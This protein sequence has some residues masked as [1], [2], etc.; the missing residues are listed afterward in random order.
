M[1]NAK[2]IRRRGNRR[3]SCSLINKMEESILKKLED[4]RLKQDAYGFSVLCDN[5]YL[6]LDEIKDKGLYKEGKEIRSRLKDKNKGTTLRQ[7]TSSYSL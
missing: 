1:V 2:R 5:L 3:E 7:I 4:L 6:T